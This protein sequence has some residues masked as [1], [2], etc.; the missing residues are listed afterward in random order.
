MLVLSGCLKHL[1]NCSYIFKGNQPGLAEAR[2]GHSN[3]LG[4]GRRQDPQSSG[5]ARACCQG[6][7]EVEGGAG[8]ASG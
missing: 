6:L 1:N 3:I 7:Q 5:R 4:G 8:V 2:R